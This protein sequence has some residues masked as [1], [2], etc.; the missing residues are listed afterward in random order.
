MNVYEKSVYVHTALFISVCVVYKKKEKF[1]AKNP[2]FV[3]FRLPTHPNW[4]YETTFEEAPH[5]IPS[6]KK[7]KDREKTLYMMKYEVY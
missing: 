7:R 4:K 2:Y 3:L 5:N 6:L 1:R